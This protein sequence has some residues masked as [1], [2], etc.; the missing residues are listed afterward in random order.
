MFKILKNEYISKYGNKKFLLLRA[1]KCYYVDLK[2]RVVVLIRIM[3]TAKNRIIKNKIHK[4]LKLKYMV[5]INSNVKIGKNLSV[6]HFMGI[7]IGQNVIIGDNCTIYHNVTIGQKKL[8][9][10]IIGDNV[11]IYPGAT[12][13]G[14][15]EIGN[16]SIIQANSVVVENIPP[17]AI[18]AG[19]TATVKKGKI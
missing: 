18:V 2:F 12:I 16:N 19:M 9:Y 13:I 1:I 4:K 7:V 11:I 14:N 10:P 3:I 8:C 15:I 6:E 5:D 17:N